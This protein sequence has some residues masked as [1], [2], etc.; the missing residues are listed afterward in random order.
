MTSPGAPSA[1]VLPFRRRQYAA[2]RRRRSLWSALLRAFFAAVLMVGAPVGAAVWIWTS[3][4]FRLHRIDVAGCHRVSESW[5]R[6]SLQQ[7]IGSRLLTLSLGPLQ[8]A[9]GTDPWVDGVALQKELP[10]GL[11]VVVTERVPAGLLREKD[12]RL[13]YV[14]A[15]GTIIAPF[16]PLAGPADLPLVSGT[17]DDQR[18][19]AA[20]AVAKR[21]ARLA[22]D[23]GVDISEIGALGS[24]D[25]RI[26]T[27]AFR[28][29]VLVNAEH[30]E[31]AVRSLARYRKTIERHWPDVAFV[32]LRF[33]RQ[34]IIQPVA[35]TRRG[36][37]YDK[38][39]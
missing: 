14:D 38:S 17:R 31:D 27:G 11:R 2:R 9:I 8:E 26:Y 32:D 30:L 7:A 37:A 19:A 6:Q 39:G 12:G 16:D 1:R 25:F 23:W 13:A 4:Q 35:G 20:L 22:P 10:D 5:V 33:T 36:V 28:F 15:K 24:R 29:P 18:I 34:I 3:P 21:L